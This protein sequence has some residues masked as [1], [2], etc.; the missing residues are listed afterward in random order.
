MAAETSDDYGKYQWLRSA[1]IWSIYGL[2][3]TL[4]ISS[5]PD[6]VP[7]VRPDSAARFLHYLAGSRRTP[8]IS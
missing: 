7:I 2:A 8:T 4:G 1:K 5:A 3:S 6:N